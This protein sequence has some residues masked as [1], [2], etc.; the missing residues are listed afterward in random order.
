M[1]IVSRSQKQKG[2]TDCGL[3]AIANATA[4]AH[5]KNPTQFKQDFMRAHLLDC[6]DQKHMSLFPCK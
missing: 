2:V 3:F 6:F 5:G 4:I 1:I